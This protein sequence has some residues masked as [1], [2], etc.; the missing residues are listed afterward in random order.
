MAWIAAALVAAQF[1]L[2]PV[3]MAGDW[4]GWRDDSLRSLAMHSRPAL[5]CAWKLIGLVL[6]FTG[7]LARHHHGMR[8][9]LAR[10]GNH[11]AG[12]VLV[13]HTA[14]HPQRFWLVPLLLLHL[15]V[16]AFWF[17][18]L[19]PLW[20]IS[21]REPA[22]VVAGI[23]ARFS[24]RALLLVP[25]LFVAGAMMAALLLPDAAALQSP[26]GRLLLAKIGLF[27]VLMGLAALNRWRF[28]PRLAHGDAV[29]GR[30]FR[31]TLLLGIPADWRRARRHGCIDAAVLPGAVN[32][33]S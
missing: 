8:I 32:A 5:A 14:A 31:T 23:V 2:E 19:W 9:A 33:A 18:A 20:Q 6:I 16:L 29:A 17:G 1:A 25:A 28:W 13:G 10:R 4:A 27:A 3:R 15:A 7:L 30:A 22:V 24:A 11:P 21:R 26:Y 12:F